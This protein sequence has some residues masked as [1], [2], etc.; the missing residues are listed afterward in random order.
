MRS[1]DARRCI[2]AVLLV[3][4]KS[5]RERGERD[6]FQ[7]QL[8]RRLLR[9][10]TR[11]VKQV[12]DYHN[13]QQRTLSPCPIVWIIEWTFTHVCLSVCPTTWI[14]WPVQHITM[15]TTS[16]RKWTN[17]LLLR[18]WVVRP[19]WTHS[20]HTFVY[21][22]HPRDLIRSHRECSLLFLFTILTWFCL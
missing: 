3:D 5:R 12:H 8:H 21:K 17:S 22:T 16:N 7:F 14:D 10:T 13:L 9:F 2:G 6:Q 18:L 11:K 19:I 15:Y 20:K 4:A 1:V